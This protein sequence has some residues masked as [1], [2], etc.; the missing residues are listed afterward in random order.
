MAKV[1][2]TGVDENGRFQTEIKST[3]VLITELIEKIPG[4]CEADIV[5]E[6][7]AIRESAEQDTTIRHIYSH[8]LKA[9]KQKKE[10]ES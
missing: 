9:L 6:L 2:I 4:M 5:R 3:A 7:R 1:T 8:A 10:K